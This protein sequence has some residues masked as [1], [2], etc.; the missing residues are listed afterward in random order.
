MSSTDSFIEWE[1]TLSQ[2]N[3]NNFDEIALNMFRFQAAH[4]ELYRAY[5]SHLKVDSKDIQLINQIPFLP[6]RFF[7]SCTIKTGQWLSQRI[8][9]SSGTTE[10]IR[11]SHHLWDETFYL[12]HAAVT[13][14]RQFGSLQGYHVLAL[15]P[16]YDTGYSSLVAMARYFVARSGSENS[17]FFL[18]DFDRLIALFNTLRNSGRK[19]LLL[20]VSH[21]LLDLAEKG[22]FQFPEIMV[23]ETG[24]MKGR[25]VEIT[26]EELHQKIKVGLGVNRIYSEYG[27]TELCSQ[28]Y[29]KANGLFQ[30]APT[31]KVIIKEITDPFLV[32]A[33]T[34]IINVIDL[35]N[36]H[37]CGFIETQDLGR[38]TDRGFEV[39]GRADN[40]EA[41][42]C[43]LLIV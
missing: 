30:C 13:F 6:I 34:G 29:S 41:R 7:K 9:Q 17:G 31:M 5:L 21:A 14:E 12:Q 37:S 3:E 11:S 39:L 4:N 1:K 22:P 8:Y 40:S 19:I 35:A 36:F 24:G 10:T 16:S 26:R 23:M 27:M 43:N 18:H 28:A 20:G 38:V 2:I 33:T 32:S 15:L 42:G 25:K